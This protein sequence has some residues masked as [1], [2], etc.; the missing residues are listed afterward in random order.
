MGLG[1]R[2]A[3]QAQAVEAP[4][5]RDPPEATAEVGDYVETIHVHV[6]GGVDLLM[7]RNCLVKVC[8][9]EH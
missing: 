3:A 2:R 8:D 1:R 6:E 7:L 4:S 9:W 5:L